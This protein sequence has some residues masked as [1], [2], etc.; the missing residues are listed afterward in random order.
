MKEQQN[1]EKAKK[2][3]HAGHRA[4]IFEKA[5]NERLC[6][7]E[8]LELLL[9]YAV[10]RRDTRD[11]AHDLLSAYGSLRNVLQAGPTAL[12]R[13][14]GVGENVT[15]FFSALNE[16]FLRCREDAPKP[17]PL[18]VKTKYDEFW[19]YLD[20]IYATVD[21]EVVDAYFLDSESRIYSSCRLAKGDNCSVQFH[22]PAL[23]K[24]LVETP[25]AG[26]VIVHNHPQSTAEPS[27]ADKE[28]TEKC[29]VLCSLHNVMFCDHVIYAKGHRY[30][31][32]DSGNLQSISKRYSI[33][34]IVGGG[35]KTHGEE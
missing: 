9:F 3:S 7:S 10:P 5:K 24:I 28:M 16:L 1:T 21:Y 6:D 19:K 23:S 22:P 34:N 13:V 8:L 14:K 33:E 27:V 35:G 30:S 32:Y 25:P 29:Q 4:R 12:A 26:L 31:Y 2:P 17:T 20:G 18:M 11:V 15:A